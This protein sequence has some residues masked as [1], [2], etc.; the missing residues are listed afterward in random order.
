LEL[1]KSENRFQA[2]FANGKVA[3]VRTGKNGKEMGT[4]DT[5]ITG[6]GTYKL[7]F[8]NVDCSLRLWVNGRRIDIGAAGDYAPM[9]PEAFDAKDEKHEGWTTANDVE[10]PASI[11]AS[12]GVEVTK[13]KLWRDSYFIGAD[14]YASSNDITAAKH[15]YY[16]QP[17]H[18][19]CLGDNSAQ[20]SDGR[21][22]GTVP[23]RLMLGRAAFVFFPLDRIGFIK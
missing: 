22:W 14:S 21:V 5:K 17:G 7:R 10:A 2:K 8:A 9:T 15:T 1:S 12:Q 23:E 11:G 4:F 13:L 19:L 18:Y 3:L 6:P 20:S 16:V